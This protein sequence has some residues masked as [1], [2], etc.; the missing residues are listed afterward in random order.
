LLNYVKNNN[1][2]M[3]STDSVSSDAASGDMDTDAEDSSR[4]QDEVSKPLSFFSD[5]DVDDPE[6][7][8]LER[9]T[10]VDSLDGFGDSDIDISKLQVLIFMCMA[11]CKS[12]VKYAHRSR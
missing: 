10:G 11:A 7:G 1:N 4:A 3:G 6:L 5:A 12:Y 2:M 8:R 9:T